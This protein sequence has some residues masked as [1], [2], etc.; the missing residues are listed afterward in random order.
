MYKA[1]KD[2][3]GLSKNKKI[4]WFMGLI[5]FLGSSVFIY[6]SLYFNIRT[7]VRTQAV[8]SITNIS[9]LNEDSVSRSILNRE[10]L[11]RM[12]STMMEKRGVKDLDGILPDLADFRDAYDFSNMGIMDEHGNLHLTNGKVVD[13]SGLSQYEETWDEEFHVSESYMPVDGGENAINIF[14]YPLHV[15]GELKY[16][17]M[18][19]YQSRNLTERMNISSMGGKGY[20][21]ILNAKGEAVIYP[22]HYENEEYA[23]LMQHI[24]STSDISPNASGDQ[25]FQ[26][27][28]EKYYAHFEPLEIN[29]WYLMT[30]AREADVFGEANTIIRNV[31]LGMGLLWLMIIIAIFSTIQSMVKSKKELQ[32]AVFHDELVSTGNGNFLPVF[33]QKLPEEELS[34]MFLVAFDIDRFKEFNYIYGDDCGDNLLRYIVRT[35][36]EEL[37]EDYLFRTQSD[38]FVALIHG[39]DSKEF[40][41]KM[42][43]LLRRFSREIEDGVIQPFDISAGVRR[44]GPQDAFRRIMSDALIAKGTIKGI[45][46]QQYAF[47][48]EAIL[49]ERMSYMEMESDFA[50][51]LKE[52][53]FQVFYQPKYDMGTGEI[54][55]A[56][57]LV[58]WVKADGS[59]V[60]PGAFIPCFE[61]SRQIIL[62]DEAVLGSVCRQMR[63][64]E[65][66]GLETKKVSVN[67]SRVH[68]KRHGILPKIARIIT[69]SGVD[70]SKLSF[71]ITE[72]ALYE[73]SIPLKNIVD[74]LHGLGC[75]V[76]MDDYGVGVS[77]PKALAVNQFDVVKLDKSFIDGIGDQRM[78]AVIKSTISLSK[79]LGMEILAEGVEEKYQADSLVEWGCRLAQGFYYSPPVPEREYRRLLGGV[80]MDPQPKERFSS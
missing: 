49:H 45:Q 28:G 75:R 71:E 41:D 55:G 27:D 76:D 19:A 11:L 66:E 53:E 23:G 70:P 24:Y 3:F 61:S 63:E 56:E 33:F 34:R 43:R 37:S 60:S 46:L 25:Y 44:V 78:E 29:D 15:D 4:L 16:V 20:S 5:I 62:L 68:L 80:S 72:S 12:I 47:Y 57:A 8:N 42:D 50:R 39:A 9:Q 17:L 6:F 13:V 2:E 31:L 22:R 1:L 21:Y 52:G 58:R 14:S 48:N 54:V 38:H 40:N 18:A 74:F 26:Y 30:C 10:I 64:M 69:E 77:G 79:T 51:A 59:I 67:L 73:D 36:Q 35:F 7:T 32:Q 65:E